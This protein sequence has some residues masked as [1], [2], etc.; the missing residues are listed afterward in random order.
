MA[1]VD[2][3]EDIAE[4]AGTFCRGHNRRRRGR[5]NGHRKLETIRVGVHGDLDLEIE[6]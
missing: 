6:T 1:E 5:A 3:T 4:V 2:R